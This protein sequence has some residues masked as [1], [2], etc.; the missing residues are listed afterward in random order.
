M[1][2]EAEERESEY[3]WNFKTWYW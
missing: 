2:K 1:R 3:S